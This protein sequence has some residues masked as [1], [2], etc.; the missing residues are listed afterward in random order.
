VQLLHPSTNDAVPFADGLTPAGLPAARARFLEAFA[1]DSR[2]VTL[3]LT[4]S[5]AIDLFGLQV[6]MGASMWA[7]EQGRAFS[8]VN[9]PAIL[10]RMAS[11]LG[12]AIR[13]VEQDLSRDDSRVVSSARARASLRLAR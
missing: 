10:V 11:E 7:A 2:P 6:L 9:A 12:L 1:R 8:I 4:G 3:D 13:G 5:T